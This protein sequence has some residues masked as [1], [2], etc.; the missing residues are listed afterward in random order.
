[1]TE[2]TKIN[3]KYI[4]LGIIGVVIDF[5]LFFSTYTWIVDLLPSGFIGLLLFLVYALFV[6]GVCIAYEFFLLYRYY[7]RLSEIQ[8]KD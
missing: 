3:V 6:F 4:L 7:K 1:M 5:S 2:L 8:D